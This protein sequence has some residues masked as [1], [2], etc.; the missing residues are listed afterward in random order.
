MKKIRCIILASLWDHGRDGARPRREVLRSAMAKLRHS[1]LP[2]PS[3]VSAT[4]VV[5]LSVDTGP[6]P[7]VTI[8]RAKERPRL[9]LRRRR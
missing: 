4:R 6:L 8:D 1:R 5:E 9:R 7:I 2:D 3:F